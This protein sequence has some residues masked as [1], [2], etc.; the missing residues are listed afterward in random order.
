MRGNMK[1]EFRQLGRMLAVVCG[2]LFAGLPAARAALVSLDIYVTYSILD[3]T[4]SAPLADGSW[5]IVVGSSDNVNDGMVTYGTTNYIANSAQGNDIVLGTVFIGDNSFANTGKFFQTFQYDTTQNVGYVYVRY[6]QTT[7]SDITGMVHY[8]QSDVFNLNPTNF[9]VVSIDAASLSSLVASNFD[10]FVVIPEPGT[11][12]LLFLAGGMLFAARMTRKRAKK[13]AK[14]P[15]PP[16][17]GA[18][19]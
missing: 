3:N 6:F 7:G 12:Q 10:N 14:T 16:K 15:L 4:G 2:L 1:R 18:I 11:A 19:T 5:V 9:G 17:T 13:R 8:G